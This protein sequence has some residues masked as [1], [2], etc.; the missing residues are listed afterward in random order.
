MMTALKS[1]LQRCDGR[2][3][4]SLAAALCATWLLARSGGFD[5]NRGRWL[6]AALVALFYLV[7]CGVIFLRHRRR[8]QVA[9]QS[10]SAVDVADAD[11]VLIAFASQTGCAEQLA[12]Q[13]AQ[14][15]QAG[16]M[17]VRVSTLA[18]LDLAQLRHARR[19]LFVISTTGEGDAP[20][21]A[22]GFARKVMAQ[23]DMAPAGDSLRGLAYGVLALGDRSYAHYCAFGRALDAWLRH[24][25]ATALF[26]TVEVDNGDEG[27]LRHWQH[28][29][30]VLSGHTDM[31]DWSAPRYGAWQLIERRWL[32]PGSV[33]GA[34][35][36][37]AF[38]V[39]PG[40]HWQAGDIAEVGP[41][42]PPHKVATIIAALGLDADARVPLA[43]SDA[44]ESA[45]D[46]TLSARLARSILPANDDALGAW[47]GLSPSALAAV[48][49]ALPHREYSIASIPE[50]GRLELL[51]RRM[52]HADGSPG[53]GS[54]WLTEY[55]ALD[56]PVALRVRENRSFQAPV[57]NRPLILI[58]NGTGLAGLRAHL[59]ARALAGH[60]RN[61]LLF[62]ERSLAQ[63]FF[64]QQ[65]IA[66]WQA[67]GVLQR[68]DL[69]FSRDQEQRVYVQDKV[70]AAADELR[71]WVA[72]DAA[73]YVCGSLEGMA[74]GVAQALTAILG[75]ETLEAMA[76]QGRYRRD[77]Y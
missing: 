73:I 33:G 61:W 3:L 43:V 26:D 56:T 67:Q 45:D 69:A 47:R 13:S 15:L 1:I 10:L 24:H 57:D 27:A 59:K 20:D 68:L 8:Q 38:A 35:F 77:V 25:G 39:P 23:A 7:F 71:A 17:A 11:S 65:E 40:S 70:R 51:V 32:N 42:Q 9:Q 63:D 34:A 2:L 36:H 55:A 41:C 29:L 48:L 22:A 53:L 58:G 30:G 62:G 19:V 66:S 4:G 44:T 64:H 54:G 18:Q 37:L 6:A 28:Q 46:E 76:E 49:Q 60:H 72:A 5:G 21:S 52:Q 14:A 16:G 74:A 50:D 31:A 75:A 12:W